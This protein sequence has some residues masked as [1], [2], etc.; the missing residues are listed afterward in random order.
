MCSLEVVQLWQTLF[1]SIMYFLY[2]EIC[3]RSKYQKMIISLLKKLGRFHNTFTE[4]LVP[5]YFFSST[6]IT[7]FA[8]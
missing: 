6:F 8:I 4:N 1:Y 5:D 7:N 3:L 2:K